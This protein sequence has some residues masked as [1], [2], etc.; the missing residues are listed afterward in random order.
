ML[1]RDGVVGKGVAAQC[2]KPTGTLQR[3]KMARQQRSS[4][5]QGTQ[6]A[7]ERSASFI[8]RDVNGTHSFPMQEPGIHEH[9]QR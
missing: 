1:Q 2:M 7:A 4:Q 6:N 5:K 9:M 8:S 3:G